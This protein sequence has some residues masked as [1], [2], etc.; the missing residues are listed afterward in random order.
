MKIWRELVLIAAVGLIAMFALPLGFDFYTLTLLTAFAILALSLGFVW[1]YAG[2]LCF[3][4]AAFYGLGG[5]A[6]AITAIN[7]NMPW[8][9]FL[10]AIV[11]PALVAAVLGAMMFY[12]RLSDVYMAVVTL[13]FTLILFKYMNTTAGEGYKIGAAR[14]GGF[15]GIPGFP[16]LTKPWNPSD[17]LYD[18]SLYYFAFLLL[19]I[20]YAIV[21]LILRSPFGRMLVGIRE[22]EL[23]AEL[24]GYDVRLLKTAAFAIGGAI[25][26][27]AGCIFANWAEIV[28]PTMFSLGQSS[29]I[30]I[31]TIVGGAGT[32]LGPIIGAGVLGYLK[33]AL[34]ENT[35]LNNFV[36]LG[37]ILVF[38][39]LFLPRGIFPAL[40]SGWARLRRTRP[41][42]ARRRAR[43]AA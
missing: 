35:W 42:R 39:V 30:I 21:R 26:G 2:I 23:R 20:L 16:T 24:M 17:T 22:N 5:Y 12:G 18:D 43:R 37:A 6:F 25:A 36:I 33:I 40:Q 9:G 34:G 38:A 7:S 31:W 19:I 11:I 32:L 10:A 4:Q 15:N 13:V 1:G 8:L 3:G 14:L 28:T 27:I 41:R 29:E